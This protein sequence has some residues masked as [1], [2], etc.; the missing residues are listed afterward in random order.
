MAFSVFKPCLLGDFAIPRFLLLKQEDHI[1][2]L[3]KSHPPPFHL[4]SISA[5]LQTPRAGRHTKGCV[6]TWEYVSFEFQNFL[7]RE[8]RV[9][10]FSVFKP[11]LWADFANPAFLL[12]KQEYIILFL[13]KSE[14]LVI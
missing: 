10:A 12:L 1:L 14:L 7:R 6:L 9:M 3:V 13:A 5:F 4:A 8:S 2:F 11:C